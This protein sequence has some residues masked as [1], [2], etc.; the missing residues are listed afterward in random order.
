MKNFNSISFLIGAFLIILGAAFFAEEVWH[1]D[2]PVFKLAIGFG[3]IVT[4]LRLISKK[5]KDEFTT[6]GAHSIFNDQPFDASYIR[7]NV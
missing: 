6:D 7:P 4:G 3:L 2:I 5:G 1:I